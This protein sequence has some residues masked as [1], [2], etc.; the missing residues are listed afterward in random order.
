MGKRF[1]KHLQYVSATAMSNEGEMVGVVMNNAEKKKEANLTVTI[2]NK[3]VFLRWLSQ[4]RKAFE[5]KAE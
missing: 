2:S 5:R 4:R 1:D 3:P